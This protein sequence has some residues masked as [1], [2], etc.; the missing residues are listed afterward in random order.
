MEKN[1][2]LC[3]FQNTGFCK[4][5]DQCHFRHVQ[6]V[7]ASKT[8]ARGSCDARHP[9]NC[10]HFLKNKCKFGDHCA[11]Q[12]S[13]FILRGDQHK[14]KE[15]EALIVEKDEQIEILMARIREFESSAFTQ[16]DGMNDV[17]IEESED[18]ETES[19]SVLSGRESEFHEKDF[20]EKEE[21]NAEVSPQNDIIHEQNQKPYKCNI[22]QHRTE[23]VESMKDHIRI[24]HG[25]YIFPNM[26]HQEVR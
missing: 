1:Q 11:Y 20:A 24:H 19:L 5:R 21:E 7:C 8:C 2:Q 9:K 10:K 22:C 4:F 25:Q 13:T 17:E 12:H 23:T 14:V 6:N 26:N 16:I 15:L 18:E 3:K